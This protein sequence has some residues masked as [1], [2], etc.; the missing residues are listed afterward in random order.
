[1]ID[2]ID[3]DR[4]RSEALDDQCQNAVPQKERPQV[5]CLRDSDKEIV[6]HGAQ[7]EEEQNLPQ[8]DSTRILGVSPLWSMTSVGYRGRSIIGLLGTHRHALSDLGAITN[9]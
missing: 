9:H 6:A 7:I 4:H 3:G 2:A 5:Q 1:M 8:P